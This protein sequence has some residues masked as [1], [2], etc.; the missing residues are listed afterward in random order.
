M[1]TSKYGHFALHRIFTYVLQ[2]CLRDA[3]PEVVKVLLKTA[4][5]PAHDNLPDYPELDLRDVLPEV[6]KVLLKASCHPAHDGFED[7]TGQTGLKCPHRECEG[8]GTYTIK[9]NLQR[10]YQ[11]RISSLQLGR[12]NTNEISTPD[13]ECNAQCGFCGCSYSRARGFIIHVGK[14]NGWKSQKEKGLS[15]N[16]KQTL[17]LKEELSKRSIFELDC[18]L[19]KRACQKDESELVP[20]EQNSS[21]NG[22]DEGSEEEGKLNRMSCTQS[23]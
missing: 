17:M 10:H 3:L 13:I 11:N 2:L 20:E 1:I 22:D 14:C 12:H 21:S 5:Y 6:L 7:P 8:K 23:Q 4:R 18:Q 16:Q 15:V 9:K 19:R